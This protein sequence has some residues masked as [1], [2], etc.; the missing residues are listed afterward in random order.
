MSKEQVNRNR[1][2]FKQSSGFSKRPKISRKRPLNRFE[3][4]TPEDLNVGISA[5]KLD[6]TKDL[7]DVEVD[8]AFSYRLINF[9]AVFT[10][11]SN[12]VVCKECKSNV[13]FSESGKRGLGFKIVISCDNCDKTEVPNCPLV[14]KSYEINRRIILAMRLLG[15]GLN[16][17]IKFCAFMDLPRPIF[18]SF[19]DKIV[20]TI[21]TATQHV[22]EKS[23]K[24]A[25]QKEKALSIEKGQTNGITVSGDGTW[26]KRG[27][28]S[29]F[30]LVTL[31]GW[32]TGK[33]VDCVVKSK[34][35][36]SCEYWEQKSDTEEYLE[37]AKNHESECK[38]NHIGSAGKMEVDAV[39]E[40]FQRSETLHQVK[41]ANYIGDG[42]SKTFKGIVDSQPY[43]NFTVLKK[44]CIDHVQ[45]RMGTRLRNL[46]KK[47]VGLGGRNQLTGKLIDE[48][49]IYYGLAIRR[50]PESIEKM[51]N[52]IWATLYHKNSTDE[53]PQHEKC[54]PG[55]SSWCSWQRAKTANTL[56]NYHHKSALPDKVFQAI[57][58]V[59]KELS[60]D[61]LLNRCIGG[62]T[63]NSNESFN[64]TIW[65]MAPKSVSSGKNVLDI[66]TNIAICIFNDGMSPVMRIMEILGI[67][68]GANCYN[69]CVESDASR[70]ERS[71]RSLTDEAKQA[72][73]LS[74]SARKE[75]EEENINLEGRLYGAGI[76]D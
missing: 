6:E 74:K 16:G 25:A 56:E 67:T 53:K 72:R 7:Y 3:L 66:A 62:F 48:L 19:Y 10:A 65:A 52:D 12:V 5:R 71:E 54:P 18:Q 13:K 46:K 24:N 40:M 4:E 69:F 29:L 34:Y 28:S 60:N 36:K 57:E 43:E 41:Y 17:I 39:I 35:C 26:R 14:N 64:S 37:W 33:V 11:I 31:I 27:F 42:D 59:Y 76:A 50:N 21:S 38:A 55:E 70:I 15:V 58:P 75:E 73:L 44:E 49:S 2:G 30:G 20:H 1:K 22:S 23:M 47:N 61:D 9:V 32:Y 68:I 8:D 63:Q 51:K 45:K